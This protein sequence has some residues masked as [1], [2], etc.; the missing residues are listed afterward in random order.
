M[1]LRNLQRRRLMAKLKEWYDD[2]IKNNPNNPQRRIDFIEQVLEKGINDYLDEKTL[3]SLYNQ[4]RGD[5]HY[6]LQDAA[7][8]FMYDTIVEYLLNIFDI[9][10]SYAETALTIAAIKYLLIRDYNDYDSKIDYM[11]KAFKQ[12]LEYGRKVRQAKRN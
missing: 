8:Y 5:I 6:L 11:Q 2:W 7:N 4:F 12:A 3:R 1:S 9:D 10:R